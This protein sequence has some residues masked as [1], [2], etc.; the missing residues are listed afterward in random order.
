MYF[1]TGWIVLLSSLV[2]T[3]PQ[4]EGTAKCRPVKPLVN[5]FAHLPQTYPD[6]VVNKKLN[7]PGIAG[8]SLSFYQAPKLLGFIDPWPFCRIHPEHAATIVN[9]RQL[10]EALAWTDADWGFSVY[11]TAH[12]VDGQVQIIC[13]QS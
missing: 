2:A 5:E 7:S 10:T 8:V 6:D 4:G 9:F 12:R 13:N 11:L 3:I 1:S